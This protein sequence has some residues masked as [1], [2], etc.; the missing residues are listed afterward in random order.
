MAKSPFLSVP[1]EQWVAQNG[2]AFAPRDQYPVSSG[3]T[4]LITKR[5]VPTWFDATREEQDALLELLGEVKTAVDVTL[6]QRSRRMTR[7][8]PRAASAASFRQPSMGPQG[9][10]ASSS[11]GSR[12]DAV[13]S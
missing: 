8:E 4:L 13:G 6:L 3:H 10:S 11:P 1:P 7:R 9:V 12:S 5:V 2:L